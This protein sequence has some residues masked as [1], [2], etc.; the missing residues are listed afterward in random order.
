MV[1]VITDSEKIKEAIE[2]GVEEI[3]PS[4][5]EFEK[6]L[7]SGKRIRLYLGVDPTGFDLHIGHSVQLKK[8]KQFQDLGHEV[9]LLIG[10]F[11]G[12]IG[13]P[14][15]K[16]K[17]RNQLTREQVLANAKDYQR[18]ASKILDFKGKNPVKIKY[19]SKWLSKL[20]F[21]DVVELA[22][23]FTVQQMLERDMFEKR[24][25][26]KQPIYFHEFLYPLMQGYDSVAMDVDLEVGGSDQM[27]NM[28][29]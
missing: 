3:Y 16:D 10:D 22:S 4:K 2:R 26:A 13:D 23:H 20:N 9:I 21:A 15:G 29:A 6:K 7:K 17:V 28:M 19:N 8:L 1:K 25:K 5:E 12:L 24:M 11:T 27:F 18:Q 14:S